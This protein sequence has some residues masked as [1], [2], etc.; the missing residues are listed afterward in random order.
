MSWR[1]GGY[2]CCNTGS[3]RKSKHI[4]ILC[5]N[6]ACSYHCCNCRTLLRY[7]CLEGS[8]TI[9]LAVITVATAGLQNPRP[10][11]VLEVI[12]ANQTNFQALLSLF[13]IFQ[14]IP[15]SGTPIS[16]WFKAYWKPHQYLC[17]TSHKNEHITKQLN[18]ARRNRSE[19]RRVGKECR[20]RW[21]PYH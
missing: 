16:Q 3:R 17:V 18:P 12:F 9:L 7:E 21:S 4:R 10:V 13:S 11:E 2:H 19:E 20:S 6:T 8:I 5:H 14:S 15:N 1:R